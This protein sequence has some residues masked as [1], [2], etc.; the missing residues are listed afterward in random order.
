MPCNC[1]G[2]KASVKYLVTL[3]GGQQKTYQTEVE[4][5]AAV[6]RAGGGSIRPA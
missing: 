3:P 4:A 2:K 1:G 6:Q 5:K